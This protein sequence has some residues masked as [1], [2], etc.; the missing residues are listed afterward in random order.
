MI[1]G[2]QRLHGSHT[3]GLD[4][5]VCLHNK[6][7]TTISFIGSY[8]EW[9]GHNQLKHPT[10]TLE[11]ELCDQCDVMLRGYFLNTGTYLTYPLTYS[12]TRIL[13]DLLVPGRRAP[14][15]SACRKEPGA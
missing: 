14:T 13:L 6:L 12:T 8:D 15:W 5:K 10:P 7:L 1:G 3:K 4:L 11:L 2:D 9:P